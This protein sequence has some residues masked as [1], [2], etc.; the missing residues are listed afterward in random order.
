VLIVLVAM[1]FGIYLIRVNYMFLTVAITV[2]IS[3]LYVQLGQ[4]GWPIL[5]LRL[6]ETAVGV[7][8]VVVTVLLVVPLRPQRVL[9]TGLLLWFRALR[10]LVEAALGRLE[11]DAEALR[12]L[13]REL[14]AGGH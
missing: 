6:V 3:Q 7:G 9:T 13:V 4:F 10:A 1:F 12:P 8:A 5:L 2:M 14:D 11:R